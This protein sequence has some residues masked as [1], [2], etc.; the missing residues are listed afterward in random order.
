MGHWYREL[1]AYTEKNVN[2]RAH[3]DLIPT[4]PVYMSDQSQDLM[5][6]RQIHT[7]AIIPQKNQSFVIHVIR[8]STVCFVAPGLY[9]WGRQNQNSVPFLFW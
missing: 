8:H 6:S 5:K 1:A 3:H 7:F 9:V 4:C 2:G